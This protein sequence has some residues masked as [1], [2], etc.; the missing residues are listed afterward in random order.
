MIPFSQVDLAN[1][2]YETQDYEFQVTVIWAKPDGE[3]IKETLSVEITWYDLVVP[4]F[5]ID[6]DKDLTLITAE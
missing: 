5:R 6:F 4:D 2:E 1:I 3:D